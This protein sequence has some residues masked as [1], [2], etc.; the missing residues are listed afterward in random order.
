V[1]ADRQPERTIPTSQVPQRTPMQ[2]FI[3]S[4]QRSYFLDPLPDS[5][6]AK[7]GK[8]VDH[9]IRRAY[10]EERCAAMFSCGGY[11]RRGL[12]RCSEFLTSLCL[13]PRGLKTGLPGY[14]NGKARTRSSERCHLEKFFR[15]LC[16]YHLIW[17]SVEEI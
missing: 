4:A 6:A 2:N 3:M 8:H 13:F 17:F 15:C 16:F 1:F 11:R 10:R 5:Q 14:A 12:Q 7:T 9:V